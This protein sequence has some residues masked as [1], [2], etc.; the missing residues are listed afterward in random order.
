MD[1]GQ[2]GIAK[3]VNVNGFTSIS[4]DTVF[5]TDDLALDKVSAEATFSETVMNSSINAENFLYDFFVVGP[6]LKVT[7]Y[8]GNVSTGDPGAPTATYNVEIKVEE[9]RCSAHPPH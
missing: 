2:L 8:T 5:A 1:A 6:N 4:V 9:T 3:A 7:D